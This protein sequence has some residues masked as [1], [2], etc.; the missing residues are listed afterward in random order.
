MHR[1]LFVALVALAACKK[2]DSTDPLVKEALGKVK[3]ARDKGCACSNLECVTTVQN[4]LGAWYME[5]AARLEPLRT[6]ATAKQNAE[7]KKLTDEL[8]ACVKKIEA[9]ANSAPQ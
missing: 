9:A 4:E 8:D 1:F 5:N 3:E 7:S 6:K 2:G